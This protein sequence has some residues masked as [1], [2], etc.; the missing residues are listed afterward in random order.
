MSETPFDQSEADQVPAET[1]RKNIRAAFL[2]D[3]NLTSFE[4]VGVLHVVATEITNGILDGE[5]E[6]G[7]EA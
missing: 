3:D 6:E 5:E 2:A 4:A 1:F 7:L